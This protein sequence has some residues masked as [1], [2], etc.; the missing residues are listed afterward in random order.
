MWFK[1]P[2]EISLRDTTM[3]SG[4]VTKPD[5]ATKPD[6]SD[7]W[8]CKISLRLRK[9]HNKQAHNN[10]PWVDAPTQQVHFL[11]IK[12]KKHVEC[13]LKRAQTAILNP[14]TPWTVY[15]DLSYRGPQGPDELAQ[16]NNALG[17]NTATEEN[18]SD[19]ENLEVKFSPN[20][21][22]MEVAV[23]LYVM[24][25]SRWVV[26]NGE[27]DNWSEASQPC[28][29]RFTWCYPNHRKCKLGHRGL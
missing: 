21:V 19:D 27:I 22:F 6:D 18:R 9:T 4:N 29:Y 12:D 25:P 10:N 20:V 1:C 26:T 11:D 2:L 3:T 16:Q 5:D 28:I 13:A 15:S 7:S 17:N 8:S 24:S 23:P 14:S